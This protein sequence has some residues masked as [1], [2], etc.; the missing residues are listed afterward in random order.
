VYRAAQPGT[1]RL[2]GG[3]RVPSA[4][5]KA[6]PNKQYLAAPLPSGVPARGGFNRGW[7]NCKSCN[8]TEL[9]YGA[10]ASLQPAVEARHPNV[11]GDGNYNW[12]RAGPT[13]NSTAF[14]S[15]K[16]GGTVVDPSAWATPHSLKTLYVHG[17]WRFD[18]ADTYER[19]LSLDPPGTIVNG[20][21]STDWAYVLDHAPT[22]GLSQGSRFYVVGSLPLLDAPNE[23]FISDDSVYF[24]PPSTPPFTDAAVEVVLSVASHLLTLNNTAH[25]QF[26]GLIFSVAQDTAVTATNSTGIVFSNCSIANVGGN[27]L[28]IDG[29]LSGMAGVVVSG[30]HIWGVGCTAVS[31]NRV[32]DTKTLR[33]GAVEVTNNTIHDFA[34]VYRTVQ[35]GIRWEETVGAQIR[36]NEISHAAH[37][38]I[39]G[40]QGN[41]NVFDGNYLH[42]LGR[43]SSDAG[44]FYAGRHWADRGNIVTNNRFARIY[45]TEE[46]AETGNA[47]RGIY[48]GPSCSTLSLTNRRLL[49]HGRIRSAKP[50]ARAR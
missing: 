40:A 50:I 41:D 6:V 35:P 22:Y 17:F 18:W 5:F 44:A 7:Q 27:A 14:G 42:D 23:Y 49:L 20:S 19:V 37:V 33:P 46:I 38:G 15:G 8:R 11:A 10:P 31:L 21:A 16:E 2:D 45:W 25:L 9:F 28:M 12:M 43:G 47:V 39:I 34:R 1:V 36:G 26:E 29:G 3:V 32:G 24:Y 13:L 48:L 4:S 30:C